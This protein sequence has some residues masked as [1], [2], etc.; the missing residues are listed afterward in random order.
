MRYVIGVDIGG[1]KTAI[2]IVG[3]EGEVKTKKLIPTDQSIPPL[4]MVKRIV[5]NIKELLEENALSKEEVIGV[6]IGAPGPLDAKNGQMACPP[7]LPNWVNV[8]VVKEVS[9]ALQLPVVL[10]NDASAAALAEKW[11]G[12]G[13]GTDNFIYITVS[14]GIGA[15]IVAD[16][17]LFTGTY[18]NAGEIGHMV[19]DPSYGICHCGQKGCFEFIASGTAISRLGSEAVGKTLSTKDVFA[20]YNDRHPEITEIVD[21]VFVRIGMGCVSLI[22]IFE[23]EKIIIGGGVSNVGDPLINAVGDYVSK[24]ALSP[25][26][27][28]T[29]IVRSGFHGDTGLIGAAALIFMQENMI[30]Q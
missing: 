17:K 19:V 5:E 29:E 18:G 3:R 4:T 2:G 12:A 13:Q 28:K 30:E 9:T 27:R 1:T 24:R 20:L 10:E 11:L 7:N 25:G 14:T 21:D 22:N 26:G 8:P 6:G 16:G 23:P 15:G